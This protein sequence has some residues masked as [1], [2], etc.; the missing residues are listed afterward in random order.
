[1][2]T[3]FRA[4]EQ[5]GLMMRRKSTSR[6][7]V[8]KCPP[9]TL[10]VRETTKPVTPSA[11]LVHRAL[12]YIDE[13]ACDG[14][15][16]TDAVVEVKPEHAPAVG[17]GANEGVGGLVV[18]A[19]G[20]L[21]IVAEREDRQKQDLRLGLLLANDVQHAPDP[22]G[23]RLRG[24]LPVPGVVG[25]DH[26]HDALRTVPVQFAIQSAPHEILRPVAAITQIENR[27]VLPQFGKDRPP[28]RVPPMGALPRS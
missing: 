18:D 13:H 3:G 6:V 21:R 7:K 15:R 9:K 20:M 19:V 11:Q 24:V 16:V 14:I 4:A 8:V 23:D 28:D 2:E 5:L 10:V 17:I 26:Q 12:V 22:L 27:E 25:S 1:M